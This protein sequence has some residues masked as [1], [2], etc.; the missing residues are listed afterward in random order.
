MRKV[1]IVLA[2]ALFASAPSAD[3]QS[4]Q[5]LF[6]LINL[7]HEGLDKVE[8]LINE[9]DTQHATQALLDYYR[10]RTSVVN[11]FVDTRN[12][13]ISDDE[14][15]WADEALEH[16][17]FV[18]V[19]YQPSFFYGDD[20]D[21]QYWPVKDNELRWQLHRMKWWAPMGKRYRQT[22]DERY[23]RE[24]CAQ[25]LDWIEKNPLTEYRRDES[26]DL[27]T[28]DNVYFAWRP[29]EVS[30]R[31]EFQ[32]HQFIYFLPSPNFDAPFLEAFLKNYHRHATHI[33][34]NFSKQGNHL[35]FE[36]QRLIFAGVFFQEFKDAPTWRRRGVEILNREIQRQVYDDGMQY[37]LDPHYHLEAI[38]IFFNALYMMD[39]NGYRGEFP[40]E[41]LQTIE[42]MIEIHA[43]Y[44]FPDYTNPMF[45]DAKLHD[46]PSVLTYYQKWAKVFADNALICYMASEGNECGEPKYLSRAF[47]TSGFYIL[48]NGW[49]DDAT[50]MTIKAGPPAFWHNQ[51]DNGTF[52]LWHKGRNFF[53]DSGSYVYA[54]GKEIN[55]LRNWFRQTQVHNTL[56]LNG[57]DIEQGDTKLISWRTKGKSDMLSIEN[58]SYGGLTHRRTIFFVN[59]KFYVI[60][61]EATGDAA[62]E[63]ELNYNLVEGAFVAPDSQQIATDFADGNNISLT[64]V[65][66]KP[67]TLR[68]EQG[69]VSRSYRQ[70]E[71][72]LHAVYSVEKRADEDVVRFITIIL[73][74]QGECDTHNIT[75]QFTSPH[76]K[77]LSLSVII[78]GDKYR[79]SE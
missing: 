72:R 6:D 74:T 77:P 21:W 9:C 29:L 33:M 70:R 27:L 53:P 24:W 34:Q 47:S 17:L 31:L 36:A 50:Q 30:D 78:D 13:E 75:A 25:Y 73:P 64:V 79:L 23:T 61:D 58:P 67:L 20:I 71:S 2:I 32:I 39:A 55:E 40:E 56:T 4:N 45:S 63:V 7:N 42:R 10:N 69:W 11:P 16:R 8:Q 62:G 43:N 3:A 48:R 57:K 18:H 76:N 38:N 52:E 59:R 66:D 51:P 35:L 41:Y 37:E 46:K 14:C 19:G 44:S 49:G 15:R 12:I 22:G 54:G 5:P 68:E 60:V 1:F 65:A 28:A 26:I